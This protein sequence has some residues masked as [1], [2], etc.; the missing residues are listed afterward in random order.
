M[1][2]KSEIVAV[3]S[4]EAGQ[5]TTEDVQERFLKHVWAIIDHWDKETRVEGTRNKISGAIFSV[6]AALDGSA[7]ELPKFVVAPDPHPNDREY[8]TANGVNW[9]NEN[10][11][12]KGEGTFWPENHNATIRCDI[13]GDLHHRFYDVGRKFGFHE[14]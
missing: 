9:W 4:T 7:I 14:D 11:S 10:G 12:D 8:T 13:S 5:L 3:G 2:D 6:L 1:P